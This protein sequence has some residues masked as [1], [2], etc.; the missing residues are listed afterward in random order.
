MPASLVLTV[1][2]PDR[3]GLVEALS[4][5]VARHGGNWVESRMSRL[6]GQFTGL[7]RVQIDPDQSQALGDA[8]S[9]LE[10]EGL[11]IVAEVEPREAEG[12]TE[13][14]LVLELV[15]QDR[16][17][18]VRD[19]ARALARMGVNVEDLETA[20][21]PAPMSGETLFRARASLRK[22]A[23]LSHD[24]LREALE[25]IANELMV[26]LTLDDDTN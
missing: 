2:G 23:T 12:T 11:R 6:G 3:P 22:P 19:V 4:D 10:G 17:G 15:G 8:L 1:I 9:R 24:A 20:C 18:I 7:L 25:P 14:P 26:D 5:T 13:A 16:P 21:E